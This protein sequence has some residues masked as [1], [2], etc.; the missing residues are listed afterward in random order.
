MFTSFPCQSASLQ[1]AFVAHRAG[2]ARL[3]IIIS[4]PTSTSGIII[5]IINNYFVVVFN[6][7]II[8]LLKT[9]TKYRK[10]FPT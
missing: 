6:N 2:S 9:T 7:T 10:F 4:Y 3:A 1:S 8:V 5:I